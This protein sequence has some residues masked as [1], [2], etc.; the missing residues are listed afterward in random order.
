MQNNRRA[1][2]PAGKKPDKTGLLG[3]FTKGKDIPTTAQQ[4]L[5]YR[6][7]YRDG[8]C[9][10]EDRYYTKT[11]EYEDIN[12]Q[13]AQTE[14]QAAIFDGWSACLNYFDSSLPFQLSFLNHRS[15]PG[16]RYSVNIPMQE[17][18]YNSVRREYVEMLEN[19]IAKSNNGIVP[20][21]APDLRCECGRPLHRKGEAGACGGGHLRQL[22]KSWVS[23]AA[24]SRGWNGWSSFTGSSTPAAPTL[25]GFRGI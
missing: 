25:S 20:H 3:L 14:D 2:K 6:E 7:M 23:S 18:D 17:D 1:G 16:S 19:Q 9:R 10:V 24:P 4:T 13:L 11:I 8:V 21:K 12:Y 15:R 5:P 22:Q